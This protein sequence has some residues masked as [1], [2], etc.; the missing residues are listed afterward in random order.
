ML[1]LLPPSSRVAGMSLSAAARATL[2]P[3][4]VEPG[5][6]I[7]YV[8]PQTL[9]PGQELVLSF[10]VSKPCGAVVYRVRAGEQVL[11]QVRRPRAVPGEME[12]IPL[13][14]EL[15]AHVRAPIRVE[16]EVAK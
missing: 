3:P 14:R 8:V 12:R 13:S 7:R 11:R 6:G 9:T 15:T 16:M 4:S 2:R 1:A 5:E 10:R